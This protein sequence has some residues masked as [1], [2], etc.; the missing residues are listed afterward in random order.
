MHIRP[1]YIKAYVNSKPMSRVRVMSFSA[2]KR[3]G[4][5]HKDLKEMNMTMSNFTGESTPTLGFLIT[6]LTVGSRTTTQFYL[7]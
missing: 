3:F 7:E 1:L 4:K 2:M 6:K 5:G